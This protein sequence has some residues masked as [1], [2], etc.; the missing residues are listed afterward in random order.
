[1]PYPSNLLSKRSVY[2][3]QFVYANAA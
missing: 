2:V 1:M 3:Q